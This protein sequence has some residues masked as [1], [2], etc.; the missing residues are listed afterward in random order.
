MAGKFGSLHAFTSAL[1]WVFLSLSG[2]VKLFSWCMLQ[3]SLN[4]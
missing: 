3:C 1:N 4:H 2:L